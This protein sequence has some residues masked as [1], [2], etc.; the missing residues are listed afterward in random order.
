MFISMKPNIRILVNT[1]LVYFQSKVK[2]FD[3]LVRLIIIETHT[4][5]I[6]SLAK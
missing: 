5:S 2:K 3:V 6:T 1:D 4:V